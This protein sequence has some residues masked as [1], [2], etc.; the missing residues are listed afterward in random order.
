MV[1]LQGARFVVAGKA[2]EIGAAMSVTI[3]REL[4][5]G[6]DEWLAAR[7]GMITASTMRLIVPASITNG[8]EGKPRNN[9]NIRMHLYE[10]AA[11]RVS[12]HVEASFIS[13]DMLRG[14]TDEEHALKIYEDNFTDAVFDGGITRVGFITNDKWGFQIGY[15]PDALV[16]PDGAVE[17]KSRCQKYQVETILKDEVPGE[18]VAQLQTG[19]MVSEREWIDFVSYCPGLPYWIK[20]VYPDKDMQEDIL[21][22]AEHTE[23]K[24]KEMVGRYRETTKQ[25]LPTK[26]HPEN[27]GDISIWPT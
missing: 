7:C 12:G 20:R 14:M 8:K 23:K 22:I 18:F 11:Q 3:H 1:R 25:M 26:R 19:L 13:D 4:L 5:Q 27:R 2:P 15:S 24:I 9:A 6:T 10:L 21:F 17:V 16:G